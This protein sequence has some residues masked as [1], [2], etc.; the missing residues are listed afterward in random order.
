[1]MT[2][3]LSKFETI[4]K[5]M[6]RAVPLMIKYLDALEEYNDVRLEYRLSLIHI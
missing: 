6:Q 1:M 3:N 5:D 4:E 2:T